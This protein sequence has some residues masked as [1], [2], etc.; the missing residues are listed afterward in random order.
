M[1]IAVDTSL[2][3]PMLNDKSGVVAERIRVA[4]GRNSLVML[5]PIQ[6]EILQGCKGEKEWKTVSERL[7]AVPTIS[8]SSD[9]WISA[10]R[11][12]FDLRTVGTTIR[13]S[14]DCCIAQLAIENDIE[15]IHNDRDFEAIATIRPLKHRRIDLS[16]V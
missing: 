6:M 8:A 16:K 12:Y 9:V 4:A 2:W 1:T 13:S 11:I 3:L 7:S 5:P 10:A 15:L 14:V